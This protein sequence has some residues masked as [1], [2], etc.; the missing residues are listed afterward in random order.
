[1]TCTPPVCVVSGTWRIHNHRII[2]QGSSCSPF[3]RCAR[4]ASVT[5]IHT[6]PCRLSTGSTVADD[7]VDADEE[8][9]TQAADKAAAGGRAE[10]RTALRR[11]S[12]DVPVPY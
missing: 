8:L 2:P 6:A 12:T 11:A 10:F 5:R 1:M 7:L 4:V 9:I 3:Q